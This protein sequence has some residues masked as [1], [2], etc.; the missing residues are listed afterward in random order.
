MW[1]YRLAPEQWDRRRAAKVHA[2]IPTWVT[3]DPTLR[4]AQFD[5]ALR[6]LAPADPVGGFYGRESRLFLDHPLTSWQFEEQYQLGARLGIRYVHPYWDPDVLALAYRTRPERL[7]LGGR[8][9][10]LVRQTMARRFPTLG[11]ERHRKVTA[12]TFFANLARAEGPPLGEAHADFRGLASLGVVDAARAR[13]FMRT[14]WSGTPHEVGR[15]WNLVNL[16]SWTRRQ[17]H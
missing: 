2:A 9:K 11:F 1:A 8:S 15:A 7:N 10:G 6:S 17:L 13:H 3:P 4:R 16:E 12:L 5:R 14:A